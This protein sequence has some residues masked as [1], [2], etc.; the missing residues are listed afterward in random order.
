VSA[1]PGEPNA[2]AYPVPSHV[3]LFHYGEEELRERLFDFLKPALD[4]PKQ[5]VYMCGPPGAASTFLRYL[6]TSVGRNLHAEVS[7]GR[8]VLGKGDRDADEQLQNL[9]DPVRKLSERGFDLVRVVGP[10]DWDVPGYAAPEDF[11]WYESRIVPAIQDFPVVVMCLYDAARLP[12]AAFLYGA[13]ET[14]THTLINGVLSENPSYV[15]FDR[16]LTER[17]IHLPWLEPAQER[18]DV[19]PPSEEHRGRARRSRRR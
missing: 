17:L 15:P 2:E 19:T 7:E 12:A 1:R 5:A 10:A 9:L 13:L 14:H 16:Y 3:A 18:G 4:D 11:L 6:E 8:I